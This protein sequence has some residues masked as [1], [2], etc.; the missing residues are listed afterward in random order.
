MARVHLQPQG[1]RR[2]VVGRR[3]RRGPDPLLR[4]PLAARRRRPR[5][6]GRLGRGRQRRG[7][8]ADEGPHHRPASAASPRAPGSP[9]TRRAG[10]PPTPPTTA[11]RPRTWSPRSTVPP[12][13][14]STCSTSPWPARPAPTPSSA[15]CSAPPRPTSSSWP[16]P[17]THGRRQYAAHDSPWVTT[18]G[19]SLGSTWQGRVS[20]VGGPTLTGASRSRRTS[21]PSG[22]S[23]APT[24]P[25]PA[26]A[27]ATPRSAAPAPSTPARSAGRRGLCERGGIGR[28]DKSD[29]VARPTA[30]RWCSVNDRPGRPSTTSTRC[31]RCTST[32]PTRPRLTR[33]VRTHDRT[34]IRIVGHRA[35][36][37]RRPRRRLVAARRP[38]RRACSSPTW[39]PSATASSAP[40]PATA[41]GRS[42]AAAP[43]PRPGSA[44]SP[45]CSAPAHDWSGPGRPVRAHH[46]GRPAGR[47]L[48]PAPGRRSVGADVREARLALVVRH[49][50]LP[51]GA[52][53]GLVVG[54]QP[55][56]RDGPRYRH[57]HPTG[58]QPRLPGG[59]LLRPGARLHPAPG[60]GDAA[61]AARLV[62][63]SPRPSGSPS[64]VPARRVGVD[65]GWIRWRG[66][67]GSVT[68]I[69]V[70][71]TR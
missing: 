10:P 40:Y 27:A 64:P 53:G 54:P 42:S 14:G 51:R 52:R 8:R 45:P 2:G 71:I 25:P 39:W 38:A 4:E 69:P 17:A 9:P 66:A 13:T 34:V 50:P 7:Q 28:V 6:P 49:L 22:S 46:H 35:L 47:R 44:A 41:A 31:R 26:P 19:A 67:R 18:V 1:R 15:P 57:R 58:H 5:H 68:R 70:A 56:V 59:V 21:D 20:V 23:S 37:R 33:W 48:G 12:P 32:P 55:V 11:A 62:P 63:G 29:A 3:L 65:D 43:R 24:S 61:R 60:P 16:P 36:P 30:S